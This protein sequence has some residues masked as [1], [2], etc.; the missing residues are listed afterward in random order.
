MIRYCLKDL[1]EMSKDGEWGKSEPFENSIEMICVRGTD[2]GNARS[3]ILDGMPRRHIAQRIAAVKTLR[4]WDVLIETAGGTK[5]QI[6]GRTVLL[7]PRLFRLADAPLICASFS[8]FMRF[9][10]DLTSPRF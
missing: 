5:D 6:T 7:R 8:R 1:I 4:P 9:R 3:S 10:A 2:F